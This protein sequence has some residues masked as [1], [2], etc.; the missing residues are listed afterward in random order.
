MKALPLHVLGLLVLTPLLIG[1]GQVMFK[2]TGQKLAAYPPVPVQA[3]ILSPAFLGALT[4]YG[5]GTLIWVYVLKTVPLSYAYSFMALTFVI[6]PVLAHFWFGE[7][8]NARY[9]IGMGLVVAGLA[10]L[11]S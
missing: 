5:A 8:L 11:W 9:F 3:A 2:I 1:V 6:V 10:T 4:L 7:P